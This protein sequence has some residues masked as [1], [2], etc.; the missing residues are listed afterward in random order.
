[1]SRDWWLALLIRDHL[2]ETDSWLQT[3]FSSTTSTPAPHTG[4]ESVDECWWYEWWCQCGAVPVS[5]TAAAD[6]VLQVWRWSHMRA[7]QWWAVLGSDQL[8]LS[9]SLSLSSQL[10]RHTPRHRDLYECCQ[11]WGAV[12]DRMPWQWPDTSTTQVSS[13]GGWRMISECYLRMVENAV[14]NRSWV[15]CAC[16]SSQLGVSRWFLPATPAPRNSLPPINQILQPNLCFDQ[17]L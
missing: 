6:M 10:S 13:S 7:E 16:S 12:S 8:T 2:P 9:C 4:A 14:V 17:N 11:G 5:C 3:Y 1:M 15:S